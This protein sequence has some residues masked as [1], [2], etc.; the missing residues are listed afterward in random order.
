[1]SSNKLPVFAAIAFGLALPAGAGEVGA[2]SAENVSLYVVL[3]VEVGDTDRRLARETAEA[4]LARA[5]I[6]TDWQECSVLAARCEAVSGPN[7]LIVR[8]MPT[9]VTES[10]EHGILAR[11]AGQPRMALIHVLRHRELVQRIRNS[12]AGRADPALFSLRTGHVTGLAIA[13]EVGH[14]F[15]LPHG[16]SGVMKTRLIEEDLI[17][18]RQARLAFTSPQ[19]ARMR[20]A[21]ASVL[22]AAR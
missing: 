19:A 17:A 16:D 14:A 4:L 12:A 10:Q 15:G 3:H 13:H 21:M 8:L 6:A 20:Q 18:L 11:E 5:G 1:M 2:A 22:A 9:K 7:A